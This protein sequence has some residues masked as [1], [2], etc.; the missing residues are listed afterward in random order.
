MLKREDYLMIAERRAEGAF[1]KDIARE[2]GVHPKT[3]SRALKRG[4]EP[5][6]RRCG[7][8]E[9]K[10]SAFEGQIDQ[11][12]QD[13][14]WNASVIYRRLKSSGYA[15]GYTM[16]RG[17]IQPKRRLRPKG[18][19]RYE[20][21]MGEQ[22]QHDWGELWLSIGGEEQRVYLAVNVLGY[23]RADHVVAM[24]SLDA[25]HT[26]E[27]LIQSFEY[28]GGVPKTVLVDNQKAAVLDWREG[29]PYFNPRFR[30]LGK[31]YGFV[32]KACRP[33][34]AQTKG[35]VERIVRYVKENAL[36][37][38]PAFDSWAELNQYLTTWCDQVA[39]RRRH[40]DLR[41]IVWD[42]W[43]QERSVLQAL[44]GDRFDT[45]YHAQRQ[46]S[47]DAYVS[48]E[49][50][51][52]S[53]PGHLAGETVALR[54]TLAGQLEIRHANQGMVASHRLATIGNATVL[55]DDHHAC[56]W[57]QVRVSERSLADYDALE[58]V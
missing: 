29:R 21:A 19:V 58:V 3:I 16:V 26:Y 23:S 32:P 50:S 12:L 55:V 9:T 41:E 6:A 2:Q 46:V 37:G 33:R 39:N 48:W 31:H 35:K 43:Q 51:R 38:R 27:A 47:M 52:Y 56:L 18:T 53:V 22:L 11:W 40:A 15:G 1:V 36:A 34:R 25:E 45:A 57:A 14:I 17:Y 24:P 44:P 30:E 49:G 28:F 4:G 20:T 54:V 5:P 10:L 8:R 7:V 13:D 42:R